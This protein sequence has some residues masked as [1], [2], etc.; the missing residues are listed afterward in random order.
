MPQY[1][2]HFARFPESLL[3]RFLALIR[4]DLGGDLGVRYVSIMQN[5]FRTTLTIS[6][7]Y[8]LKGSTH[9]RASKE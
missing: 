9:N 2:A 8:D 4:L 6:A 7:M 1:A 5:V 3:C